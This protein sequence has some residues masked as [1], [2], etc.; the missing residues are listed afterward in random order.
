LG[1][2]KFEG[3]QVENV[4]KIVRVGETLKLAVDGG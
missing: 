4:T 3:N 2:E 1:K